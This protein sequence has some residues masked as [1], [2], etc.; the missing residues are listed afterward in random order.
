MVMMTESTG[1]VALFC[2]RDLEVGYNH[3]TS[4]SACCIRVLAYFWRLCPHSDRTCFG[5][6]NDHTGIEPFYRK[7]GH[8]SS[9]IHR[10]LL[11]LRRPE[12]GAEEFIVMEFK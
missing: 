11:E 3:L 10:F 2:L 5:P 8:L 4:I 7:F 6:Q 12:E 1:A 9:S